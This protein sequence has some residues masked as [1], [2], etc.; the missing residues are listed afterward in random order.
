MGTP[1][2]GNGRREKR[3]EL[4]KGTDGDARNT[5]MIAQGGEE[6]RRVGKGRRKKGGMLRGNGSRGE[7]TEQC[8]TKRERRHEKREQSREGTDGAARDAV[9]SP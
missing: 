2:G 8:R 6:L 9:I 7:K 3:E 5:A 1:Q 4:R